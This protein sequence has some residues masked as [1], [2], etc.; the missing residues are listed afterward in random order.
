MRIYISLFLG[1]QRYI[2]REREIDIYTYPQ[3]Y[4]QIYIEIY[5]R[6]ICKVCHARMHTNYIYIYYETT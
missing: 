5:A 4:V 2:D 1:H 6:M 3:E